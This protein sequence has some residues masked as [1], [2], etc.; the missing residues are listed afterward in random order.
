MA[1]DGKGTTGRCHGFRLHFTCN[2]RGEIISFRLTGANVDN[3]DPKVWNVLAKKLYGRLFADRGYISPRLFENL[4]E[5][6]IHLVTGI[7]ADM[8]K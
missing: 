2:D 5:D 8:K 4:F 6:G 7:R 1:T 3:R